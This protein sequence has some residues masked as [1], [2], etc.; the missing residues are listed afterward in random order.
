MI[1]ILQTLYRHASQYRVVFYLFALLSPPVI[2]ET[3]TIGKGS[4]IVWEGMPFNV[5]LSGPINYIK[6]LPELPLLSI[7]NSQYYGLQASAVK[8]IGGYKAYPIAPG[9]GL[10]PRAIG[11]ANYYTSN[12]VPVT[13]SATLGLPESRGTGENSHLLP[14][15]GYDWAVPASRDPIENFYSPSA[16]RT[17]T[18]SGSWV[19]VTDGSQKA[20]E[21]TLKPMY[22]ASLSGSSSGD[23]SAAILPANIQLRISNL[24]CTVNTP[25]QINFGPVAHDPT[26]G[27]EL[28]SLSYPLATQCNQESDRIN[29][30]INLQFRAISGLYQNAPTKLSLTAGGGY[31]T[32]EIDNGVTGSGICTVASG[33]PFDNQAIRIGSITNTQSSLTMANQVTW[34]LCS[35]GSNL[36]MGNVDAAAEMLVTFN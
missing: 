30:N 1:K 28:A 12:M 15:R 6:H 13:Y 32:G 35:G 20:T 31:I 22:A 14:A 17:A 7:T 23:K 4:G 25:T 19:I 18:I 16:P 36:P 11:T 9:V 34:R 10:V 21:I 5:T 29:A 27:A 2:A 24:E 33:V 3:I 26:A 8:M